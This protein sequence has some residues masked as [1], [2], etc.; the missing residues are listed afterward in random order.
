MK[1]FCSYAFTGED[2]EKVT[3]RMR[4]VVGALQNRGFDVYCDRFDAELKVAQNT[5]DVR[6]IFHKAFNELADSDAVVAVVA[7]PRK[8]V[9]QLMEIGAACSQGIP[10]YLFEHSS[11][12]RSTYLPDLA[13]KVIIW[14]NDDDLCAKI[15][16]YFSS[17]LISA[18]SEPHKLS[19]H[20]S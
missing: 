3:T 9:G 2:I 7:S 19:V 12:S 15:D 20:S 14:S 18:A 5:N 8:S 4:G 17:E 16:E 1:I 6:A 11:A 13:D 10:L